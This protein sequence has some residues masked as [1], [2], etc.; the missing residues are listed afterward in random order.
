MLTDAVGGVDD[1]DH[2]ARLTSICQ[3]LQERKA[4]R[5]PHAGARAFTH[6]IVGV[7]NL[8]GAWGQPVDICLAGLL[9]SVYSTEMFPW[10]L[11]KQSER[12]RIREL[13]GECA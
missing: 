8:L 12:E 6:H 11:F 9:H 4:Q 3:A 5:F 13:A 1:D 7:A 10:R 2:D